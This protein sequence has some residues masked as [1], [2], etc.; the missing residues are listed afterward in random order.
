[1][2]N[3]FINDTNNITIDGPITFNCI[4]PPTNGHSN[5]MQVRK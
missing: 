5:G 1:M 2:I 4:P 3:A